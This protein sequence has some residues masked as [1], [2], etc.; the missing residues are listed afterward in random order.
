MKEVQKQTAKLEES[1][2]LRAVGV[3]SLGQSGDKWKVRLRN[4]G[5]QAVKIDW[6]GQKPLTVMGLIDGSLHDLTA[7]P[8]AGDVPAS[9]PARG[10]VDVNV[11]VKF[12]RP[13]SWQVRAVYHVYAG[14]NPD[15]PGG[16]PVGGA[17]ASKFS[18]VSIR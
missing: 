2:A 7:G 14:T 1:S 17:A 10:T 5:S 12:P 16:G 9:I 6:K 3:E 18:A 11:P 8:V 13:G 15:T 4:P